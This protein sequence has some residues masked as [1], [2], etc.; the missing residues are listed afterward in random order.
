MI[1]FKVSLFNPPIRPYTGFGGRRV[2]AT[3]EPLR[4]ISLD[5]LVFLIQKDESV[6]RA[7]DWVLEHADTPEKYAQY[8]QTQLYYITPWGVATGR[9]DKE[10][11]SP[12]GFFPIDIDHLESRE[13]AEAVR[14]RI[15]EDPRI[16]PAVAFVS[17][18]QKG[19]KAFVPYFH[20]RDM[21]ASRDELLRIGKESQAL[22]NGFLTAVFFPD[23]P[24]VV[25]TSGSNPGRTCFLAHDPGVRYRSTE[26]K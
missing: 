1:H 6:K 18:S 20:C 19:V 8:K 25:D 7:H 24:Q 12:S 26:I 17:P 2:E 10:L 22:C 9:T 13:E 16:L 23:R 11:V 21:P 5:A 15:F 14:D 3:K 4:E